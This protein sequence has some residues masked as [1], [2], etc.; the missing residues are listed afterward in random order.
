MALKFI[1]GTQVEVERP[2]EG[3][4]VVSMAAGATTT[5]HTHS[6]GYVVVPFLEGSAERVL[7]KNGR[8]LSRE[9]VPLLPLVPYYV[10]ATPKGQTTEFT[11][12]GSRLS[13]FQ[14]LV[15]FPP[16][17]EPQPGLHV[18]RI[19]I[20]RQGKTL[21]V[22]TVEVARSFLEKACGL[23]FRPTLAPDRGMIFVWP[24]PLRIAMYM[25][26]V[27]MPLDIIFMNKD[28]KI[29]H[30]KKNAIPG[31]TT[32]VPSRGKVVLALE[33]PGGSVDRLGIA[34]GDTIG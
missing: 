2:I 34:K 27:R 19:T 4:T 32:P 22:F 17:T 10:D 12:T 29:S 15:P 1:A 28:F 7:R 8:V 26:N 21:G 6:E 18:G 33:I 24:A 9:K 3:L 31:D 25:R 5:P 20:L 30:I 13:M 14:K 11:N 23:M 16:F